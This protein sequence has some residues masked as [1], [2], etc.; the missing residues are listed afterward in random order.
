MRTLTDD[1]GLLS[2]IGSWGDTL[3]DAAVLEGLKA[4]NE[5]SEPFVP[6]KS[7]GTHVRHEQLISQSLCFLCCHRN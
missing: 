3:D 4:W 2:M 6:D 7:V 1:P 5:M